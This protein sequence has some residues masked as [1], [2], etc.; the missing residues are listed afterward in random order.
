MPIWPAADSAGALTA[1]PP[2]GARE[3]LVGRGANCKRVVAET[4]LAR[5]AAYDPEGSARVASR[6]CRWPSQR[7]ALGNLSQESRRGHHRLRL[8]RRRERHFPI[9]LR[10][11]G[12]GTC[13]TPDYSP[14]RDSPS[15]RSLDP[16]TTA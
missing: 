12:H 14:Q 3:P 1:N 13:F 8:L 15:D 11:G 5:V 9:S 2:D 7:S 4:R 6:T 10:A 16:P